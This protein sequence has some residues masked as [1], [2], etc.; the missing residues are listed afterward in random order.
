VSHTHTHT[1]MLLAPQ[2][3][4]TTSD[5]VPAHTLTG[6]HDMQV[7]LPFALEYLPKAHGT[8]AV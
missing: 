2:P 3:H 1:H 5:S 4:N 7:P 6:E 8:Q